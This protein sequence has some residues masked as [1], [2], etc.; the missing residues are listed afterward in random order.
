MET[1]VTHAA[2]ELTITI[3]AAEALSLQKDGEILAHTDDSVPNVA[4]VSNMRTR[5]SY[6]GSSECD[7]VVLS[8]E[9][10][11]DLVEGRESTASYTQGRDGT[12]AEPHVHVQFKV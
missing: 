11:M 4:I 2:V 1:T 12:E 5:D 8:D 3:N 9:L 7:A 10:L 6:V